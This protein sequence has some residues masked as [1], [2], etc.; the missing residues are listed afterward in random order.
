MLEIK[1]STIPNAGLG[2]FTK[3]TYK[4]GDWIT[5]YPG[6]YVKLNQYQKLINKRDFNTL[7]Y[8]IYNQ[9]NGKTLIG[10]SQFKSDTSQ[11]G[12]LI[13]DVS[14][15]TYDEIFDNNKIKEYI[16]S[17]KNTNVEFII[18]GDKVEL[19]ASKD[20]PKNQ[21]LFAHYGV[22]YWIDSVINNN[23]NKLLFN[24]N[25]YNKFKKWAEKLDS[26]N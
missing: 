7:Y 21:E 14:N 16:N 23:R 12:H 19:F 20:I 5:D 18:S 8:S 1:T 6:K 2:I 22:M 13:N 25:S 4:S 11:C 3:K 17:K 15:I 9:L 24:E 26:L 10:N